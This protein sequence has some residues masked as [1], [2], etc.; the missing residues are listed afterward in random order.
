MA[1]FLRHLW[2]FVRPYRGRF[3]LG[4]FAGLLYAAGCGALLLA[5]K[6]VFDA[7]FPSE[8]AKTIQQLGDSHLPPLLRDLLVDAFNNIRVDAKSP[9]MFAIIATVP[10]AMVLRGLGAYLNLYT[11]CWLGATVVHDLRVKIFAHLQR[12]SLDFFG[13]ARTGDLLSRL[14]ND[15]VAIQ[16]TV[17]TGFSTIAKEPFAVVFLVGYL[18]ILQRRLTL[19]A[20]VVFPL[21]VLPVII[22]GRKMRKAW[23]AAQV[24]TAELSDV[25][26]ETFTGSRVVKAYNLEGVVSDRFAATSRKITNQYMR[27]IRASEL[28]GPVIEATGSVGVALMLAYV[29]RLT[30]GEMPSA[31]DFTSF[32]GALFSLYQP[33]KNLSRFW[34]QL[35]QGRAAGERLF[36]LLEIEPT[37]VEPAS[38]KSLDASGTDIE[39]AGVT[40]G[41]GEKIAVQDVRLVAKAG[42]FV[43][44]VG[45][46]GSGKTTLTNLLLR[47]Y[48]P[49]AGV[50][51]IGGTDL[52]E[53]S[54]A[55]LRNQIAVVTQETI[56]FND[57]IREN[58][59]L[60]RPGASDA[61]VEAAARAANAHEFVVAKEGGYDFV[62]GE[63]GN[64]LSGGQRQR[65]AIARAILKNAP[66]LV[67][68]EATS[69]LD[70]ESERAVQTALET[71]MRG[72]TTLCIAHRLTTVQHADLIVVMADGRIVEQ[73]R[74][75]DLLAANGT[76]AK[77]HGLQFG[78]VATE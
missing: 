21:V 14:T 3:W 66:I 27:Y 67:L 25:M 72:R 49:Q 12:L 33:I 18:L 50:V 22:Y 56:L 39:F 15:T 71:L 36:S 28:P 64:S 77:L 61:E 20:L 55:D 13:S 30:G 35:E 52:R 73:G 63:R 38:P 47:F 48:D 7:I 24:H 40:F 6:L 8:G 62:I 76:Y 51:R 1:G 16:N 58:I 59:R 32:V 10:A 26:Q 23:K 57:S 34:G 44:L 70:T 65:L 11:M 74:H 54:T 46:S 41:Y 60:G 19:V 9:A 4:V 37:V 17:A 45:A 78:A 31:G 42:Q 53:V 5:V 69:A 43:A 29:A 75:A 68:D 2:S